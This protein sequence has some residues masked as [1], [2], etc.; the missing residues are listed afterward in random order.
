LYY[1]ISNETASKFSSGRDNKNPINNAIVHNIG[2]AKIKAE[3]LKKLLTFFSNGFNIRLKKGNK[4][5]TNRNI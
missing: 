4:N 2:V 1:N 3:K 5:E